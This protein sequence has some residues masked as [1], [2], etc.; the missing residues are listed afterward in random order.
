MKLYVLLYVGNTYLPF[1][2]F[3]L[4]LTLTPP[5]LPPLSTTKPPPPKKK[6]L[7]AVLCRKFTYPHSPHPAP[8]FFSDLGSLSKKIT[9][10]PPLA[11]APPPPPRPPRP[12]TIF[13][14]F[15]FFV[16]KFTYPPPPAPRPRPIFF[17]FGFF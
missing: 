3:C 16:K 11:T 6:F 8:S 7:F 1:F 5:P 12:K 2:S 9:Y 13:F 17:R 4:L 15:G 14:R 10:P